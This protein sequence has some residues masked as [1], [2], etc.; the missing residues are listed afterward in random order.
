MSDSDV[1]LLTDD[2]V[3]DVEQVRNRYDLASTW[4]NSVYE[5]MERDARRISSCIITGGSLSYDHQKSGE[6]FSLEAVKVCLQR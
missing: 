6:E 3:A 4:T 2:D 5:Q 1:S